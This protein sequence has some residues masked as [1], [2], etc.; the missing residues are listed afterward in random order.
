MALTVTAPTATAAGRVNA[1]NKEEL[2]ELMSPDVIAYPA[3]L[4]YTADSVGFNSGT[5]ELV[6]P[7]GCKIFTDRGSYDLPVTSVSISENSNVFYSISSNTLIAR[8]VANKLSFDER[9]D[10]ILVACVTVAPKLHILLGSYYDLAQ[11]EFTYPSEEDVYTSRTYTNNPDPVEGNPAGG[12]VF[13][14]LPES[15]SYTWF[16][17]RIA[18]RFDTLSD[19][20]K[21]FELGYNPV[22]GSASNGIRIIA[23]EFGDWNPSRSPIYIGE[24]SAYNLYDIVTAA[25]LAD[26]YEPLKVLYISVAYYNADPAVTPTISSVWEIHPKFIST[27]LVS[28]PLDEITVWGDS[29]S[30]GNSWTQQLATLSGHVVNVGATGG[31]NTETISAR[32]GGDMMTVNNITIPSTL[33]PVTIANRTAD[34]GITTYFGKKV[35][36]LLQSGLHVNPVLLGSVEGTL[37]YTGDPWPSVTGDW[38]FTRTKVG[39]E[40]VITRPTAMRTNFDVQN[41]S[42]IMI[43][44]MGQNGG[45]VD[46]AELIL[47]HNRMIKHSKAKRV[48]V[49][50][51]S[52]GS[53][54]ERAVYEAAMELEFGRNFLSLR[55]YLSSPLFAADGTTIVNC[56]GLDDA[57]L[58]ATAEDLTA[59]ADGKVPPQML[60]DSVH[61]TTSTKTVVGNLVYKRMTELNF[62]VTP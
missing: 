16:D 40:V 19:L 9:F 47:Q 45:F 60:S 13:T 20:D 10:L 30:A 39:A 49:L 34:L 24:A 29:L 42:G 21:P 1:V 53:A 54:V 14:K 5:G 43:V 32:Q 7:I 35:K 58:T 27:G 11:A 33:T 44:F 52:S 46:N 26:V 59:I 31:E 17:I 61:F 6:F 37:D 4:T 23:S 18:I 48:L 28:A 41:N 62:F 56:Y 3:K 38:V 8:A 57:G 12:Y 50:G 36:P 2:Q 25:N 55:K 22:S 15:G 51:L